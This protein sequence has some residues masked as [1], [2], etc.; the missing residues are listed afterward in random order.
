[1]ITK[2]SK[3]FRFLSFLLFAILFLSSS[4]L[5]AQGVGKVRGFVYDKSD[6]MPVPYANVVIKS[7]KLGTVTSDEGYFVLNDIP[8]GTYE[9][10]ISFVGYGDFKET[11]EVK[12][13]KIVSIKAFLEASSEVLSDV[14]VSAARQARDSKVLTSVVKLNPK[15]ITQFSVG[16][17][18]DIIKALQVMPGVVTTGDQGGQLF[19]R[20]GAPIQNLTL[21]DGMVVYNPFHSIGFFS[22][23]DTDILQSA[24][25]H[26]GGFNAE[27]G[28]RN[29]SVLDIKTRDG[30]R[31][32]FAGKL[33]AS[34]YTAKVVL[35]TPIGKKNEDGLSNASFLMS[36]RTSYLDQSSQ[37]FYPY[38]E[39]EY[40]GLPFEFRDIY[41]KLSVFGDNGSNISF[42]G[43]NFTD[44]V[45][46]GGN[47]S[48][49]WDALGGGANFTVVPSQSSVLM[50]GDIS[51]SSYDILS[52]ED[53]GLPSS[54]SITSFNGGLDF[55]YF[56]GEDDEFKYGVEV[57]GYST[58]YSIFNELDQELSDEQ[59]T[60]ELGVF[61][62]YKLQSN[63][64]IVEP[65]LRIQYYSSNSEMSIEPRIGMKYNITE[66]LRF[67]GS[68]GIYSQN[69]VAANS[70]RDVV[71]LFYGFLSGP[72][73]DSETARIEG[74]ESSLQK[75]VHYIAGFEFELGKFT[76]LNIEGYIKDFN[77]ITNINRN[78]LYDENDLS[79]PEVLRKDFVQES[80]FAQGVDFL[81][82]YQKQRLYL[83]AAYSLSKVTRNDQV[84]D[85]APQFDRRH[86]LN[87][88]GNY[89]FGKD[90]NYEF[91]LRY[92]MGSGFPF[93]P[94][95]AFYRQQTFT[96]N[97]DKSIDY[98]YTR[99]NGESAI[100]YGGLNSARLPFYH[101]VDVSIKKDI[102]L[103]G[104]QKLMVSA[105]ATNIL[106]YDN[107][108]YYDRVDN[109]RVDQLPIMPTVSASYSF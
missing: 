61:F 57:L 25:I 44:G 65:G 40:D 78:K 10:E 66:W 27:Y 74:E 30:N 90:R 45:Q 85:Y 104:R 35:E 37:I 38:V 22:V 80:G 14:E 32:N 100:Y 68:A 3:Q 56:I 46:F 39:T 33:S 5:Y 88:V 71:N 59:N 63:R 19:I 95:Q 41:S 69:L 58:T 23:F 52:I 82:K 103:K 73:S 34:T 94:T 4:G 97:G 55:S 28:S 8:V 101:R 51:Y 2:F 21:L 99:E 84:Q 47:N 70:D 81:L 16:G 79:V 11:V 60:T 13:N 53:G 1:M 18:P 54:S 9:V 98:D 83:W 48:I 96:E 109:K 42:F 20:G 26:T 77:Q 87:L 108:F 31:R 43:F 17:D 15:E 86:N 12:L 91:S 102:K 107:I 36:A 7:L 106:N 67:K 89:S 24:E 76:S 75:A 6:N 49:N 64:L 105:G 93:T 92:N 62:K 72:F 29:S 50:Q